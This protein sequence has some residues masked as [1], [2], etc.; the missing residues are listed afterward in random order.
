MLQYLLFDCRVNISAWVVYLLI[1]FF[2][3]RSNRAPKALLIAG[4]LLGVASV[5]RSFLFGA[6]LASSAIVLMLHIIWCSF[7]AGQGFKL[8]LAA[9]DLKIVLEALI[10]KEA[11]MAKICETSEGQDEVADMGND[12][13]ELRLLLKPLKERAIAAYG[14]S[15]LNL[16]NGA[17]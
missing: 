2:W 14:Q 10:E 16:D 8:E 12:L 17:L 3:V 13:I 6:L 5:I 9:P 7:R 4:I 11:K 15:I 1:L